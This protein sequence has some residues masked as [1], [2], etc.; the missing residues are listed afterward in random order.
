MDKQLK[1]RE[2]QEFV[3]QQFKEIEAEDSDFYLKLH[4][5][6]TK[7]RNFYR[8]NQRGFWDTIKK[9]WVSIDVD[10]LPPSE[11]SMLVINNQFRPQVKTLMKEFS[12]SKTVIRGNAISDSQEAI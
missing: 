11:A 1:S 10:S 6:W 2:F 9:T 3:N 5:K 8:G 7:N 12:R 4:K